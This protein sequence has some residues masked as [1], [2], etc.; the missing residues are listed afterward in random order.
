MGVKIRNPISFEYI[1]RMK[2]KWYISALIIILTLFGAVT[3]QQVNVPNQEIVLQFSNASITPQDTQNTIATV[4]KHLQNI[5]VSNIQ[6]KKAENG[7]LI[8]TYYSDTDVAS[9]KETFSKEKSLTLDYTL[10]K[11]HK[12]DSNQPLGENA[13]GYN[14]DIYEI[15][16]G[17][18]A[19]WDFNGI[20][21][22]ELKYESNRFSNP[23]IYAFVNA[24][25]LTESI[26]KVA[27]KTH[28]NIAIAID[29]TSHKT[30]EV[31]AGPLA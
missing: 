9:I 8:I 27:Y 12:D 21:V 13:V 30:P 16:N 28:Y 1:W 15:Q 6:V 5:G 14:L 20:S 11:Q 17:N 23:N 31:R 10:N 4:K 29:N 25:E 7:E 18:D 2:S 24:T 22:V 19:E 3:Q 26:K